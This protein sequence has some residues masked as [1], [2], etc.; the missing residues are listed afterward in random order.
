[1]LE[2]QAVDVE[3]ATPTV[4]RCPACDGRRVVAL[5]DGVFCE[6]CKGDGRIAIG[7]S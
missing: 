2:G 1:M 5:G 3:Q 6:R 4:E 7:G